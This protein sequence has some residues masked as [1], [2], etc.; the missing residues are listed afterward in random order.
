MPIVRKE[1]PYEGSTV[2]P[3]LTRAQVEKLLLEYGAEAVRWTTMKDGSASVEFIIETATGGV[4]K[5][6]ACRISTPSITRTRKRLVKP[7]EGSSYTEKRVVQERDQTAEYR[8][9]HWY[10]KSLVEAASYGLMSV[11]R[12][13]FTH[14]LFTLPDGTSTTAGEIAERAI[15][16][17]Q[18]PVVPGFDAQPA[19]PPPKEGQKAMDA[20]FRVTG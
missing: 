5:R 12:V 14:I 8:L 18:A 17:G 3:T 6:F 4:A 16:R 20:E 19:L 1:P 15:S 11:E 10:V 7:Y 13:F 9:L 2:A